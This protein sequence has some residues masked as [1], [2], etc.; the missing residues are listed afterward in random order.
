MRSDHSTFY[1]TCRLCQHGQSTLPS[2]TLS[3]MADA[4]MGLR[5]LPTLPVRVEV[6]GDLPDNFARKNSTKDNLEA[7]ATAHVQ[8]DHA[9]RELAEVHRSATH[10]MRNQSNAQGDHLPTFYATFYDTKSIMGL[11]ATRCG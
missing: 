8:V 11:A 1:L 10:S 7:K 6:L 5:G 9:H 4:Y 2:T 3:L